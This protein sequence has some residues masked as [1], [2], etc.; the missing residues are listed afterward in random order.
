MYS[1]GWFFFFS[2]QCTGYWNL[3]SVG[4]LMYMAIS[5]KTPFSQHSNG[6]KTFKAFMSMLTDL[7]KINCIV[8]ST[9]FNINY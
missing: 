5:G 1:F 8:F 2:V 9:Q 4:F 3:S 7:K 6:V